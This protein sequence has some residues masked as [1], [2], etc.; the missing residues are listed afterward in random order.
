MS[1]QGRPSMGRKVVARTHQSCVMAEDQAV[2]HSFYLPGCGS[3]EDQEVVH[4]GSGQGAASY[5]LASWVV[6]LRE[7][8]RP[9]AHQME[10]DPVKHSREQG[11]MDYL[12][13]AHSVHCLLPASGYA[14]ECPRQDTLMLL[15]ETD[16]PEVA[17]AEAHTCRPWHSTVARSWYF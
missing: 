13:L 6:V 5:R 1:C 15:V 10:A 16:S 14:G 8:G 3:V 11:G 17:L 7:V 12:K 2:E 9:V 4:T